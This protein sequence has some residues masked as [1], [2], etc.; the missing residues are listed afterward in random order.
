MYCTFKSF[1]FILLYFSAQSFFNYVLL[2]L[3]YGTVLACRSRERTLL[4][5]LKQWWWKYL[6]IAIVDV[7]ANYLVIK[8]YAYT[9]VTSVQVRGKILKQAYKVLYNVPNADTSFISHIFCLT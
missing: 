3:V 1:F 9:T 5:C 2:C 7:E 8:A 4:Q 6:L